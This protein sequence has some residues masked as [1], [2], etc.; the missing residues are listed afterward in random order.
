MSMTIQQLAEKIGATVQGDGAAVVSGCAA[1]DKATASDVSF[2]ANRKY[3][4]QIETTAAAAIVLDAEGAKLAGERTVLVA[5][6]PYYAFRQAVVQLMGFRKHP[7]PGISELAV[8]AKSAK[9]G[10]DCYI[11][12]FVVIADDA[13]IGDRCNIYP[14]CYVGPAACIGNDVILF[15]NVSV[16][17]RCVL[18]HRVT[19]HSGC[20]IGQDG[21]GYATH[22]G[23]HHKIPQTGNAVIEDDVEMGACC[24]V[25]RAT[26]GST[27]VGAGTKFSNGVTIGHGTKVGKHNLFVAQVGLAGSVETGDYVAMGGQVG[28]AGHLKI[29][30]M[31]QIAATSG[32]MHDIPDGAIF[33]G[34]PAMP[35]AE[36][37]RIMLHS[38]RLPEM[39]NTIKKL[40]K[41]LDDLEKKLAQSGADA[42]AKDGD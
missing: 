6:D 17:D 15:S 7:Q 18:G 37:K 34:S 5:D 8:I 1:L 9:V 23:V 26:L 2:L 29:G 19:L 32:V 30:N 33:G 25:D 31:V 13:V 14:H 27:V 20:V 42:P 41:Q 36:M 39:A 38:Q 21:F 35:F 11:G 16:Y 10:K 4:G 12:P 24:S 40:R 3:A 28:V 22:K